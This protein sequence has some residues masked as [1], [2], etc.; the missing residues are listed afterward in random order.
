MGMCSGLCTA[1]PKEPV[2]AEHEGYIGHWICEDGN[3]VTITPEGGFTL[4]QGDGLI[5]YNIQFHADGITLGDDLP[6]LAVQFDVQEPPHP[7]G[8]RRMCARFRDKECVRAEP[9]P[10]EHQDWIGRW[11]TDPDLILDPDSTPLARNKKARYT[12]RLRIRADGFARA[13][14]SDGIIEG[15]VWFTTRGLEIGLCAAPVLLTARAIAE[16]QVILSGETVHNIEPDFDVHNLDY[17]A[18]HDYDD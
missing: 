16:G 9:V 1:V 2:P 10:E 18:R 3:R 11:G 7:V 5:D 15:A 8:G 14:G 4:R 6:F 12:E 17:T 13:K